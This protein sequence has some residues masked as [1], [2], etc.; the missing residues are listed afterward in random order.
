MFTFIAILNLTLSVYSQ[1]KLV[2][3]S[4][5]LSEQ[6]KSY[7]NRCEMA[8]KSNKYEDLT[9]EF[10]SLVNNHLKGTVIKNIN[11]RKLNN[12]VIKTDS[13]KRPF[14]L[15]TTASWQVKTEEEI[16][17]INHLAN[18]YKGQIDVILLFWD[19]KFETKKAAKP[20][21]KNV[22][23]TYIDERENRHNSI[24]NSYKHALGFPTSF[25]IDDSKKIVNINRGGF[26]SKPSTSQK[27]LFEL[28]YE[29]YNSKLTQLILK[30]RRLQQY[31]N[32]NS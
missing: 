25:Y 4:D 32:K 16:E 6:L 2:Y 3:F 20:F 23:I 12:V 26:Y 1:H 18:K 30:T 24:I 19:S 7:K 21:S 5:A 14:L 29:H 10:D 27:T 11:L 31:P 15:S 13:L 9:F 8:L 22:I 28:N 17:A